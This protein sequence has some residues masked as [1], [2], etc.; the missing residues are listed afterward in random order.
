MTDTAPPIRMTGARSVRAVAR[1]H[2]PFFRAVFADAQCARANLGRPLP[3]PSRYELVASVAQL[4]WSSDAFFAMMLYRCK[5]RLQAFGVPVL[6]YVAHRL[7]MLIAQVSIGDR[8]VMEAGVYLPHGQVVIDGIVTV[9]AGSTIRPWVTIGPAEGE[10][11]G[12][13]IGRGV[14]IGTG[15]TVIGPITIGERTLVGANAVVLDDVPARSTAAGVP[16]KVVRS[17]GR[18]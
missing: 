1:E 4:A 8:V 11:R 5:A 15:A 9:G 12:P 3:D 18:K 17:R 16:A 10:L 6:P 2:P 13:T 14:R 7:A